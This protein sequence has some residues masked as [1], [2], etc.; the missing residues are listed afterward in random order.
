M[1]IEIPEGYE[2]PENTKDGQEFEE[3][4]T[5]K[6][7]GMELVAIKLAGIELPDE[8]DAK[9]K[10]SEPK[11]EPKDEMPM[12]QPDAAKQPVNFGKQIMGGAA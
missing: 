10:K 8:E 4:V 6:L 3:L 1:K 11:G 9:D 7:Q 5:F 2:V 12:E